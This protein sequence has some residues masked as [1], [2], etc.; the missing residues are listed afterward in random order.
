MHTVQRLNADEQVLS[1]V[2]T[3]IFGRKGLGGIALSHKE[4][5]LMEA[6]KKGYSE[7]SQI[8]AELAEDGIYADNEAL[9]TGEQNLTECE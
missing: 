6:L 4:K 2:P 1:Q 9:E 5:E 7:M 3:L 8:N